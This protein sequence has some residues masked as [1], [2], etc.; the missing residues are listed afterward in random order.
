MDEKVFHKQLVE[1]YAARKASDQELV[2]FFEL[3]IEGKLNEYLTD[4]F[5]NAAGIESVYLQDAIL[6]DRL[7]PAVPDRGKY[8]IFTRIAVAACILGLI[9]LI[10]YFSRDAEPAKKDYSTLIEPSTPNAGLPPG[11]IHAILTLADG[12]LVTLDSSSSGTIARQ[13]TVMIIKRNLGLVEYQSTTATLPDETQLYNTI[14]TPRGG[15]YQVRLPD[16]TTVWLNAA[17]TLRFPTAFH[18]NERTVEL[19]G[20]AYFEVINQPSSPFTVKLKNE[21]T[22]KVLGTRFNVHDYHDGPAKMTL[23]QGSIF[24]KAQRGSAVIKP[25]QK[26][27][28]T[29]N[30]ELNIIHNIDTGQAVAWKNGLFEFDRADITTIMRQMERWYDVDVIYIGEKSRKEFVGKM[31]RNSTLTEVLQILERSNI[32]FRVEGRKVYVLP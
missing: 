11:R 18:A 30:G 15:E 7:L 27:I 23:L 13:G 1:R 19:E 2:V 32:H 29:N 21:V 20:E 4:T 12:A 16:G 8:I 26:V 6:P 24:V 17:S 5:M 22:L 9:S 31:A 25:R 10:F 28:I 3:L 14:T